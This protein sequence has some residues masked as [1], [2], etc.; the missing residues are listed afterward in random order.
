MIPAQ[1]L[2]TLLGGLSA[3]IYA[4]TVMVI[5]TSLLAVSLGRRRETVIERMGT[6]GFL[7]L[8]F[9]TGQ[10]ILGFLW[11]AV[12]LAGVMDSRAVWA[13]CI[14]GWV[15][16]A[17][18]FR[19]W[20][21]NLAQCWI[22]I[23][24]SILSVLRHRTWYFWLGMGTVAI[25]LCHALIALV[26]PWVDD[27]LK[28][29]LVWSRMIAVTHK[30][31]LQPSLHPY[32]GLL[33]IQVEMHWAA[34]FAISNETA[35]TLWDYFCSLSLLAGVGFFAWC[36]TYSRRVAALAV[37]IIL[38]T[39]GF[40]GLMGAGKIDNASAQ[41]ALAAFFCIRLWPVLGIPATL[42]AGLFAGWAM[43]SR[44]TNVIIVPGLLVFAIMIACSDWKGTPILVAL[45]KARRYWLT[46]LIAFGVATAIAGLPMLLKNWILVGCPLAPEF[47]CDAASWAHVYRVHTSALQNISLLD[48]LFYGFVWTFSIR[49]SM[50]GNISPLFLGL[51]PFLIFYRRGPNM[52]LALLAGAAGL[53][54]ILSWFLIEPLVLFTRFFLAPL[55]LVAVPLSA[56]VIAAE[57]DRTQHSMVR[58]L[59]RGAFGILLVF[60][61]FESR[62]V[63]YAGRYLASLDSRAD[64]YGSRQGYDVA[65]WVN[66]HL[67]PGERVALGN[68][69]GHRYFVDPKVLLTAESTE[70]YQWLWNHGEWLYSDSGSITPTSWTPDFWRFYADRG[71]T[72]VIISKDRMNEALSAW[73]NNLTGL[74]VQIAAVGHMNAVVKLDR[75]Q[76]ARSTDF[77]SKVIS[78]NTVQSFHR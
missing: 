31:N 4:I 63:V 77:T 76:S 6:L 3:L 11:L 65:I 22:Q 59:V 39:P 56:S 60:L 44:Y 61:V 69:K 2:Q 9:V 54:S 29:Y 15:L 41:Y 16:G 67:Q 43:A 70:E 8:G 48:F 78:E 27:G 32:Y 66:H 47:G 28:H 71:F 34:L 57:Q 10:G 68:Y 45:R 50:L 26:P 72:Y 7:W 18:T 20:K 24:A 37:L 33:P 73:P 30:L 17:G 42:L 25:I 58:F 12:S 64:W 36:L 14:L 62:G 55:A 46:S 13:V 5:G 1:T 74:R 53:V 38:S 51:L 21:P 52:K 75:Q 40:Y 23:R 35:V 19:A 49:T